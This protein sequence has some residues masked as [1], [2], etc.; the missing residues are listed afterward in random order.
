[1]QDLATASICLTRSF[2][3][4]PEYVR[5][6][7][8]NAYLENMLMAS[9]ARGVVLVAKVPSEED[10]APK[11]VGM[12]AVSFHRSTRW[13]AWRGV[14]DVADMSAA[15]EG[16]HGA[17]PQGQ[18]PHPPTATS[19]CLPVQHGSVASVSEAGKSLA[20][21]WALR[22]CCNPLRVC[23]RPLRLPSRRGLRSC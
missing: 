11:V 23:V 22:L 5:L 13:G 17:R 4:S 20:Y 8:V 19:R 12:T 9:P 15:P 2:A 14:A 7:D 6:A 3:A 18:L 16:F 1:M 10:G 21:A